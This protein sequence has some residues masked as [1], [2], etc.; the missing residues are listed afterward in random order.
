MKRYA[1]IDVANTKGTAGMALGFSVDWQKLIKMLKNDKWS[2]DKVFY[3]EGRMETNKYDKRHK[4]L[5]K[6]GYTVRTK[7][8]FLH[9]NRLKL[10]KY[11]C[12]CQKENAFDKFKYLCT[13]C[14]K[15]KEITLNNGGSH[16]KANFD[17]EIAVDT[18]DYA[19]SDTQIILFT[20]DG[21]FRFLAEKLIEKGATVIFISS[22]RETIEERSK[23]FSTRLKDLIAKEETHA[24]QQKIKS[25]ARFLEMDNLRRLIEKE[26][27][28]KRDVS[29]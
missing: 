12:E 22:M 16:P 24:Q 4:K 27:A 14:N 1:F 26:N 13:N 8:T 15:E 29:E 18:L 28:A 3:Y 10:I 19:N 23:R 21:D 2:C 5:E 9:K 11:I 20:G 6:M 7:L 25:R 17:V